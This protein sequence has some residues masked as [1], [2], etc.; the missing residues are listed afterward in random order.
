MV[1][2]FASHI[3]RVQ[4]IIAAAVANGRQV[5]TLG[6][7]MN[8]NVELARGLGLLHVPDGALVDID[9]VDRLPPG[10]VCV[11]STG[12]Q[13]EP[14]SALALLAAGENKRLRLHEDDVVVISRMRFPGTSG[15]WEGDRRPAPAR[16]RG[17]AH[18]SR[19][20]A[21]ERPRPPGRAQDP[22][23]GGEARVVRAG[24]RRVPP[25]GRPRRLATRMGLPETHV[26]LCED[27]DSVV[28]T[29]EGVV[30]GEPAPSGYLYVDGTV[31]DVG[32]GV[33]RD[34]LALAEEGVVVVVA[35]VDTHAGDVVAPPEIVAHG[36][37]HGPEAE[38]LLAEASKAV[39]QALEEAL[40]SGSHDID[41]LRRLARRA[42]GR[43]VNERT[44]RRPMIVPIIVAV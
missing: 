39:R 24:P 8:K 22:V 26:L 25:H 15:R 13:G 28:L 4:Q 19:A 7:S 30:R 9:E 20:R 5:A 41:G 36:W 27:G 11:I 34:R 16:R 14:M 3:H 1:A 6:R 37:V 38:A 31:G 44:R 12:S 32:R 43:F 21:R 33:L 42:L 23:V 17:R 40:Q 10:E 35:T 2:C 18:R 29:A